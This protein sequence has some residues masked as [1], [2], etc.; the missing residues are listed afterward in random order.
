M[1]GILEDGRSVATGVLRTL[2]DLRELQE[3]VERVLASDG[4]GKPS[5]FWTDEDGEPRFERAHVLLVR[6]EERQ[7]AVI[8]WTRQAHS[9]AVDPY[10]ARLDWHGE[11][12][13]VRA[14]DMFEALVRIRERLEPQGWFMAVQG[15]R[16]DTFPTDVQR[17]ESGGLNVHVIDR[18]EPRRLGEVVETFAEADP[19]TLA[20]VAAQREFSEEWLRMVRSGAARRT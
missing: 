7:H 14:D 9:T 3:K 20:T 17:E 4:Y 8:N 1:L 2:V 5:Q 6:R 16:L 15:S 18:N 10:R 19:S 11:P 13:D 12:I